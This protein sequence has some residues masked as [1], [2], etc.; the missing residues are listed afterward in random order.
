VRRQELARLRIADL[1]AE[2]GTLF[3]RQGK[4]QKDRLL[5]IGERAIA[6]IGKYLGEAR[7]R[8]AHEPDEGWMFLTILGEQLGVDYLT[9]RVRDYVKAANIGKVGA[10]H[11]F[12]HSMATVM[13]EGG[14]DVRFVQEMLG[15]ARLDSTQIYTQVSI[16]KLQAVHAATHPGARLGRGHTRGEM[17]GS[18]SE[19]ATPPERE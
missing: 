13:L 16:R 3:V 2:R 14:A 18:A 15:H 17:D 1:D 7:P 8:L 9:R 4:G 5:P 19:Q 10:C 6:W 12:R 11:L